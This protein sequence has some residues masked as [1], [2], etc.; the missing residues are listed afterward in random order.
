MKTEAEVRE[1]LELLTYLVSI[2]GAT[3]MLAGEIGTL[4]WL[5]GEEP[6]SPNLSDV[7]RKARLNMTLDRMALTN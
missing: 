4:R 1:A 5:L 2:T 7:L 6:Y 3:A